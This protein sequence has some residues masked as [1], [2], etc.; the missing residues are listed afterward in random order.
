MLV[1]GKRLTTAVDHCSTGCW[2]PVSR[3][4]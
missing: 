2:E 1:Q 3:Y 4:Q